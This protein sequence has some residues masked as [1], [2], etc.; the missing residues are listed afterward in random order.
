MNIDPNQAGFIS[1]ELL[2]GTARGLGAGAK[3]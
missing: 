3:K 1:R 2:E